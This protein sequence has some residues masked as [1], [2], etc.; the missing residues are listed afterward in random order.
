MSSKVSLLRR[1]PLKQEIFDVLH[2]DILSGHYLSGAWLR[3][4]EISTRLGVSMTPVREALDLLVSSGLAER[5]AYRGVRILQMDAPDILD[6][7]EMRLLLEGSA[8][9][10]AAQNVKP[11]QLD[12]LEALLKEGEGLFN[13][14]DLPRAREVSR[15]LHLMIVDA[16]GNDLRL[17][18][19]RETLRAFPDWMLYEH[20]YRRPTLLQDSLRDEQK[21]HRLIVEAL[22]ARDPDSAMQRAVEHVVGRGHELELYLGI[23]RDDLRA[24]E[25]QVRC[26]LSGLEIQ[27][28]HP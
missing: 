9:R 20:L 24:R 16:G 8:A 4:E 25:A 13:L 18:I 28:S 6:A 17:R 2:Q 23:S 5:V 7:Y 1:K 15:K 11:A 21:E 14:E 3:Q 19:Y 22:G 26:L 12:Q 27:T 10:A